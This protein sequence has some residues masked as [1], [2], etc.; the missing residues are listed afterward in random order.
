MRQTQQ[1]GLAVVAVARHGVVVLWIHRQQLAFGGAGGVG[2]QQVGQ[3]VVDAVA[4]V[5]V[6]QVHH[7]LVLRADAPAVG[8][9]NAFLALLGADAVLAGAVAHHVDAQGLVLAGLLVEVAGHAHT[10]AAAD[11]GRDFVLVDQARQLVDLVHSA[12]GGA[13]AEQHGGG[14]AQ[15]FH[16]IHVEGVAVVE[17]RVAHAVDKDVAAG[18]EREAAQAD[19]LLACFASLE[20]DAGGVLQRFLDGIKLAVI[21]EF[22]GDDGD[23]LGD[24]AQLLLALADMGSGGTQGVLA[25]RREGGFAHLHRGQGGIIGRSGL[26][27]GGSAEAAEQQRS[28]Q[29]DDLACSGG[30]R[31]MGNSASRWRSLGH[32]SKGNAG[33][34]LAGY[35]CAT[36]GS[37]AG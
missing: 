28:A 6:E 24:V 18:G 35:V 17:G 21:D 32:S 13:A 2:R 34:Q 26:R 23:G 20:G 29:G 37:V 1:R 33:E 27:Q 10:A 19:V 14:T 9:G 8:G 3:A 30:R 12:A 25:F 22:F 16:L 15:H 5:Q 31:G 36:R 11:G 4:V 7:E